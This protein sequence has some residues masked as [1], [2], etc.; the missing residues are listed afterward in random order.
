MIECIFIHIEYDIRS[1]KVT[2]KEYAKA[3]RA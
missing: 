1:F 2:A 3:L